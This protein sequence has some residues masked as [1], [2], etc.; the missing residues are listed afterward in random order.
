MSQ[1]TLNGKA[2]RRLRTEFGVNIFDS[3]Q[4][5]NEE[6]FAAIILVAEQSHGMNPGEIDDVLDR[7]IADITTKA[8]EIIKASVPPKAEEAKK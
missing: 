3:G 5:H 8:T 1:L 4:Q 2:V 7:P 6:T